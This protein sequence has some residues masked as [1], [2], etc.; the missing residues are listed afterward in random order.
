MAN[1]LQVIDAFMDGETVDPAALKAALADEAGRDYL[2]ESLALRDV[3]DAADAA[4]VVP[5]QP[6]RP[7]RWMAAAAAVVLAATVGYYG[8]AVTTRPAADLV[9]APAPT[10]IIELEAG[11]HWSESNGTG[12]N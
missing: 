9:D 7:K 12:G 10:R 2:V 8:R 4:D 5:F 11:V 1:T 3:V 6:R